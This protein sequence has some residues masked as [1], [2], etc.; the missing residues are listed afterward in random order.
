LIARISGDRWKLFDA[1]I[2]ELRAERYP[3]LLMPRDR[4][5]PQ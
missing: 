1:V 4:K 3:A 5:Q 2:E